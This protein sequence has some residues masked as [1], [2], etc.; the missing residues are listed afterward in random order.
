MASAAS[1]VRLRILEPVWVGRVFIMKLLRL[2]R[3]LWFHELLGGA[4]HTKTGH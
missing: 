2:V 1:D 3:T 4:P